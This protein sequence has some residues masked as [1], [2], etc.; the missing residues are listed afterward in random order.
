MAAVPGLAVLA[1]ITHEG[2]R[3]VLP[4]N[5]V[6]TPGWSRLDVGLRY[7]QAL[8]TA[9]L[10]WRAGVTNVANNRAWKEAPFQFDH[11]YLYPLAP[12]S[13]HASVQLNF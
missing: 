2:E 12:R 10:V 4:D 6:S 7:M 9:K 8:P 5:S 3:M 1:F 11:A 13:L